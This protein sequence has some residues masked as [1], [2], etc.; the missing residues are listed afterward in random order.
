MCLAEA[1]DHF[2]TWDT[3]LFYMA[4]RSY[5]S[6]SIIQEKYLM[7]SVTRS[8][9]GNDE[10]KVPSLDCQA[11]ALRPLMDMDRCSWAIPIVG[12]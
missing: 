3:W 1:A 10:A 6:H 2:L 8:E 12:R 4:S 9:W 11:A 5:L 7:I